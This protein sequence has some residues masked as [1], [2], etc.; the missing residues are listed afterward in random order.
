MCI[1]ARSN[2]GYTELINACGEAR[3]PLPEFARYPE[4]MLTMYRAIVLSRLFDRKT[5][6]LQRTGHLGTFTSALGQEAIGVGLASAMRS[7]V[8]L[9]LP[10]VIM[11]PNSYA[12]CR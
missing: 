8:V 2:I 9:S 1:V 12:V 11:R 4:N 3:Q 10:I 6:A 7:D 5:I